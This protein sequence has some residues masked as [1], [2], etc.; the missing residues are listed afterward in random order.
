MTQ[1]EFDNRVLVFINKHLCR[2]N[3]IASF[4]SV[5]DPYVNE[6][7][8][9][10][11]FLENTIT[12]L[13]NYDLSLNTL[14]DDQI[15]YTFE[16]AICAARSCGRCTEWKPRTKYI[17]PIS[18]I[19]YPS[20]G[21]LYN[22]YAATDPRNIAAD[23]WHVPT[24]TEA[25]ALQ[26]SLGGEAV[27]GG[28]LKEMGTTHWLTP[29][30][31]AANESGFN[32]RGASERSSVSGAF[33]TLKQSTFFWLSNSASGNLAWRA[34]GLSFNNAIFPINTISDKKD[35]YSLRPIKDSTTLTHGQTGT[36][37]DPSGITYRTICI[38]TQEWVA[39]NIAT[40]HYRDGSPIP[41]VTDN[42]A[43]AALT[44]PG[45]CAYNNDWNNV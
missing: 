28:K 41:E 10:E 22:W 21:L 42:A 7:R 24:N 8:E 29:N 32:A 40:R 27:S 34:G 4:D 5:K 30:T 11:R 45:M 26:A 43:W 1:E 12:A 35:G 44:T 23:G 6:L 20:Y 33:G 19:F 38:G 9:R 17:N 39:D 13:D 3:I 15:F 18:P 25:W 14:T 36:Y 2:T 37:T 16:L 31:G